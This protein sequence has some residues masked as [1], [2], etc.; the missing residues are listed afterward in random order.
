MIPETPSVREA[1]R[2]LVREL[3]ILDGKR[4]IEGFSFSECHLVTELQGMGEATASDLAERLVLE[5]STISRLCNGLVDRGIITARR[6]RNDGRKRVLRLTEKGLSSALRIHRYSLKQVDSALAFLQ[7]EDRQA[8]ADGI[9]QYARGLRYARL[10][11]A[12]RIRPIRRKDNARV[13]RIIREVMTEYGAVGCGYS[14][15]DPEVDNMFEAYPDADSAFYVLERDGQIL[16]CGGVGPLR[17]ADAGTC[18]LRK[19]YLL[20]EARGT[21]VGARLLRQCLDSAERLGYQ[22]CYLETLEHM[23]HARHLYRKHGFRQ[24]DHPVGDTGHSACNYWMIK[25]IGSDND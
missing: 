9:N 3:Q 12:F 19:M 1:A 8:A 5:K 17:G 14:I 10:S 25:N 2:Q 4:S 24:V 11:S 18:E 15:Q 20:T 13:A 7:E 16:G 6:D 22:Q 23:T 21:G